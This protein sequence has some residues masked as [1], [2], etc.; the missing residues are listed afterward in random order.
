MET[1]KKKPTKKNSIFVNLLAEIK[2][3][4]IKLTENKLLIIHKPYGQN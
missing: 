2:F 4:T 1:G 3:S